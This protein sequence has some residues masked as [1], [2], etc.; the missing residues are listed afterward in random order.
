MVHRCGLKPNDAPYMCLEENTS[1]SAI[2]IEALTLKVWANFG[3]CVLHFCDID[4]HICL[5]N[6]VL[7]QIVRWWLARMHYR[8]IVSMTGIQLA[9]TELLFYAVDTCWYCWR[10]A[11][12][13]CLRSMVLR[14]CS[15][16]ILFC[17]MGWWYRNN[18]RVPEAWRC[19]RSARRN[20]GSCC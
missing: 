13:T 4:K 11:V 5:M 2:K 15:W 20:S 18:L 16:L 17:L 14:S 6:D 12:R 8:F 7:C 19:G 10:R 9:S 1:M 3:L